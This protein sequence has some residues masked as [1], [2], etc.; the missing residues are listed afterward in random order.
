M[1]RWHTVHIAYHDADKDGLLLDAVRP[2]LAGLGADAAESYVVRHWR[3]GPH[4]RLNVRTD[5]ETWRSR[6]WP[7]IETTVGAYLRSHP[8]RTVLDQDAALERHRVLAL[9]EHERGPLTPWYPNNSIVAEEFDSRRHVL[10]SDE[11]VELL[12]DFYRDATGA[13]FDML[14]HVRAGRDRRDGVAMHLMLVA[15]HTAPGPLTSGFVAFRAHAEGFL[16]VCAHT[17]AAHVRP[18]FDAAYRSRAGELADRVS[19]VVRALDDPDAPSVP[20]VRE[21]AALLDRYAPRFTSLISDD[22]LV[23]PPPPPRSSPGVAHSELHQLMLGNESY[24]ERVFSR[25]EFLHYRV[26]L[27]YTYL[28]LTRLGLVPIERFRAGHLLA[29]AVEAVYGVSAVD[30]VRRIVTPAP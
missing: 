13:L 2:V 7:A 6:V 8:S 17:G 12:T 25:P 23:G 1:R 29:N 5:E 9:Q 11:A 15:A 24:R 18:A 22:G 21:W 10:G 4:L 26:A 14:G 19:A 30:L 16:G 28:H 3:R 20:F 27:N